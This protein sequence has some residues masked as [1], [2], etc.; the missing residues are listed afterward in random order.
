MKKKLKLFKFI[1]NIIAFSSLSLSV[2]G[3]LWH[4]QNTK[5]YSDFKL[6]TRDIDLSNSKKPVN[7]DDLVQIVSAKNKQNSLVINANIKKA[8]THLNKTSTNSDSPNLDDIEIQINQQG[9]VIL[10]SASLEF[11]NKKAELY[12]EEG[13]PKLKLEG[14]VFDFREFQKQTRVEKTFFFLL[15]FIPFISN[16]VAAA[17]AAVAVSTATAVAVETFPK[18][19]NDVGRW[20]GNRESYYPPAD[21]SPVHA[22]ADDNPIVWRDADSIEV[23]LDK[24]TKGKSKSR[25]KA[26]ANIKIL[27]LSVVKDKEKLRQYTGIHPAWFFNFHHKELESYFVISEQTIPETAAWFWAVS[28]L[29]MQSKLTQIVIDTLLPS[30]V[31]AKINENEDDRKNMEE[32]LKSPIDFYS[33]DRLVMW[34]L[35]QKTKY[36]AN[37]IVGNRWSW[38]PTNNLNK[39]I[40]FTKDHFVVG[41]G[42]ASDA[43]DWTDPKNEFDI[44]KSKDKNKQS[45]VKIYFPN[46]HVRR[47]RMIGDKEKGI[48]SEFIP[49]KKM[50][51]VEKVHFLYGIPTKF[52]IQG[53][54]TIN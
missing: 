4:F 22:P 13:V 36:T 46:Y 52:N 31:K 25:I 39:D 47:L 30:I 9:E 29:T 49:R 15:P 38:D 23:D 48:E 19:V 37:L 32:K 53:K 42:L 34:N 1:T 3:P 8:K 40:G 35:A 12:F 27:R 51:N 18:V 5:S 24:L 17:I 44:D 21:Y 10:N 6:E 33:Y 43:I 11:V 54:K 7:F 16:A 50:L 45:Y 14:H 20:F 26:M 41:E 2:F 28:N